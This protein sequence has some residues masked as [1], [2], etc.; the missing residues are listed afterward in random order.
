MAQGCGRGWRG[1]VL[2]GGALAALAGL[3]VSACASKQAKDPGPCTEPEKLPVLVDSAHDLNRGPGGQPLPTVVRIYQ[4]KGTSHLNVVSLDEVM[5]NEK[6][7]LAEDL[8]E[9][10]EITLKPKTRHYPE[11]RRLTGATHIAVAAFFRQPT[12]ESWRAMV[13]LPPAD[14]FACHK[15]NDAKP[16]MQF[17]LHGYQVD[18]VP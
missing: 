7:A 13:A 16:W 1:E 17:F 15:K 12:A 9:V 6:A 2:L 5:R 3:T 14:P 18:Y 11:L 8:L 4:L 10:Q